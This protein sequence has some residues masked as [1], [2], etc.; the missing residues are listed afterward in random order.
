MVNPP[1]TLELRTRKSTEKVGEE[2]KEVVI[3]KNTNVRAVIRLL[4]P[5]KVQTH[6]D[7]HGSI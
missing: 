5:R 2:T 3:E 1:R 7:V 4:V 6:S